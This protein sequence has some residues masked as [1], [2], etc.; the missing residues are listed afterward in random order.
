[1]DYMVTGLWM[2]VV[3]LFVIPVVALGGYEL[4][5]LKKKKP[6][7][8]DVMRY[9]VQTYPLP[10]SLAIGLYGF[11]WGLLLGHLFW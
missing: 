6:L 5:V 8:T 11:I 10:L 2:W 4:Y 3:F 1:M 9:Y 7:L